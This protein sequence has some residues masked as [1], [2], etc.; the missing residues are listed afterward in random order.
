MAVAKSGPLSAG[1]FAN[2]VPVVTYLI[3]LAQGRRPEPLE[4][5]GAAIVVIALVANNMHQRR[6]TESKTTI[7]TR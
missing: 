4:L 5:A 1:L 7:S 3:A 2:F 6:V